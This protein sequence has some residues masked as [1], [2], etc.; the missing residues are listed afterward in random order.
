MSA[1]HIYMQW[2][3]IGILLTNR[4]HRDV[5][6]RSSKRPLNCWTTLGFFRRHFGT[7]KSVT[8][9]TLWVS[10]STTSHVGDVPH[11]WPTHWDQPR[12]VQVM[13]W[14]RQP[15]ISVA[16]STMLVMVLRILMRSSSQDGSSLF[17]RTRPQEVWTT[18]DKFDCWKA[19]AL[20]LFPL[21]KFRS[22]ASAAGLGSPL[23]CYRVMQL[24]VS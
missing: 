4:Q 21:P 8:L 5:P 22:F 1:C 7:A 16:S 11:H 20:I 23:S 10:S 9:V 18:K 13:P 15:G 17:L 24:R 14:F 6:A 2:H 3:D 19:V 12:F